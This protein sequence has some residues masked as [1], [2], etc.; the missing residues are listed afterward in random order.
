MRKIILGVILLTAVTVTVYGEA[1]VEVV[2]YDKALENIL[3]ER[4]EKVF[5][6]EETVTPEEMTTLGIPEEERPKK[7]KVKIK[8][9]TAVHLKGTDREPSVLRFYSAEGEE[10]NNIELK[11]RQRLHELEENCRQNTGLTGRDCI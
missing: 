7:E 5:Y 8:Y 1:D 4:I 2:T 6:R 11:P 3:E 9:P 10:L